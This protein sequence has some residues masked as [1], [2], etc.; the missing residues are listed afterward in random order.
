MHSPLASKCI[1][2]KDCKLYV[3][4][5][6]TSIIIGSYSCIFTLQSSVRAKS[7]T[8]SI[9][10]AAYT[11]GGIA[12]AFIVY[13]ILLRF[14]G[15]KY[16]LL[17]G[18][19]SCIVFGVTL[20]LPSFAAPIVVNLVMGTLMCSLWSAAFAV[21]VSLA[22]M[23]RSADSTEERRIATNPGFFIATLSFGQ[24]L[25][26]ILPEVTLRNLNATTVGNVP[27]NE[28]T[29]FLCGADDCPSEYS[30]KEGH[31]IYNN[32]VPSKTSL[33]I[34]V[35]ILAFLQ[36]FVLIVHWALV[37][38]D[39]PTNLEESPLICEQAEAENMSH[40][41]RQ[42]TLRLVKDSL[43]TMWRNL[44]S[45]ESLFTFSTQMHFGFLS[46][47]VWIT[48]TRSF[49]S[50]TLGVQ[51]VGFLMLIFYFASATTSFFVAKCLRD[52]RTHRLTISKFL[53]E[54]ITL[55]FAIIWIPSIDT[56]YVVYL[57][58]IFLGIAQGLSKTLAYSIPV[59][60]FKDI[61]AGYAFSTCWDCLGMTITG[62]LSVHVCSMYI[63][64][65]L[66]MSS[67][68]ST[69]SLVIGSYFFNKNS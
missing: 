13:P 38:N 61:D 2:L 65:A 41:F 59:I 47:F 68:I 58:A 20:F 26:N 36:I 39:Q 67:V 27:V 34:F 40:D 9:S 4:A 24:S 29:R 22:S 46:A 55:I 10:S 11:I 30:T 15:R 1:T 33:Y 28:T 12:S 23:K 48:F 54:V 35:G 50:C 7:G 62:I 17:L 37:P 64:Y 66:I 56:I 21:F 53:L 43:I 8:G 14:L 44:K 6:A 52:G 51:E 19:L 49:V 25:I 32:L 16:N 45:R 57:L 3:Y 5:A 18:D 31:P 69:S 63:L 60:Y 42:T